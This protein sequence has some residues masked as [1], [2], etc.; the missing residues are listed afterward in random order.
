MYCSLLAF[1]KSM[2]SLQLVFAKA[3]ILSLAT[4]LYYICVEI[5]LFPRDMCTCLFLT[6]SISVSAVA[7]QMM[8]MKQEKSV[9]L[10]SDQSL[11]IFAYSDICH[12]QR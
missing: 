1:A 3:D 7:V 11:S 6:S 8:G 4:W 12:V 10:L 9:W 5:S 2:T